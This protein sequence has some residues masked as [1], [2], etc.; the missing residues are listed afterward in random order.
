MNNHILKNLWNSALDLIYPPDL[1]CICCGKIIDS[2]RTYR[3]CNECMDGIKWAN[4]RLC[5]KC[6]KLL[7]ASNPGN[8][9]FNCREHPHQ[10]DRGYTCAEY[11]THERAMVF[12][13]K[14]HSRADIGVTIGEIMADRMLAEYSISDLR[15]MYDA[16][17]PVPVHSSKKAIRGYNQAE[18]IA[19]RFTALAGL[20]CDADILI[21]VRETHVMRSLGPDQ[22]RENIRGA[23]DIR[24]RRIPDI[25]G[26]RVLLVDDI[27]TTGATVDEIASVMKGAKAK[28]TDFISFASGADMV[29]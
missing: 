21:R 28:R 2:T 16:V 4:E 19:G 9:C 17:I 29:K 22:R 5:I 14:Y 3:L 11:G 8:I 13:L 24:K 12:A 6:G 20:R 10:F 1:Y 15:R 7:S 18:I 23:F 25:S 27:Y 26:M